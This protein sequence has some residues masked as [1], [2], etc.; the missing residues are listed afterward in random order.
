MHVLYGLEPDIVVLGKAMGNGY[1]IAAIVGKKKIMDAAQ[2]TFISSTYWTERVGFA[3]AL[4]VIRQFEECGVAKHLTDIGKY[5]ARGLGKIFS[6]HRLKIEMTGM[7]P[8][9]LIFIQEDDP[10]LVKTIFTQEMLKEGFLASNLVYISY[11]HTK[12]IADRYLKAAD[13]VF[14]RISSAIRLKK[15]RSL[16]KGPICHSG[17]SRLT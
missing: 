17:F 1:P 15:L 14:E 4:E 10:L 16:L 3:A 5:I 7:A 11:A 12:K 8:V 9:P 2:D 13:K 6:A